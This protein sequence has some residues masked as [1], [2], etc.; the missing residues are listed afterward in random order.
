MTAKKSRSNRGGYQISEFAVSLLFL[1]GCVVLPLLN[2][3]VIPLRWGLG[4]SIVNTTVGQKAK[5]ETLSAALKT[6]AG[7]DDVIAALNKLSGITVKSSNLAL[8]IESAKLQGQSKTITKPGSIDRDWLPDGPLGPYVYRLD[9]SVDCDIAPLVVLPAPVKI[10]GLT[11]AFAVKFHDAAVWENTGR[12][13][14]SGEFFL[15]E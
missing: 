2:L 11:S 6:S 8:I 7:Q 15:N 4:N 12:D 10:P 1:F 5:A 14:A 9:L 13:P 3:S